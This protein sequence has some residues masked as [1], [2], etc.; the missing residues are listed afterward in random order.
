MSDFDSI[1]KG[2]SISQLA[3]L[4]ELNRRTVTS[5]LRDCA[6]SGVRQSHKIYRIADAAPHLLK[7]LDDDDEDGEG[8]SKKRR[9]GDEKDLWDA[10]L[11]QQKY[12]ENMGD[13]LRRADVALDISVILKNIA[14]QAKLLSDNVEREVGLTHD[15]REIINRLVDEFMNSASNSVATGQYQV[16][17]PDEDE[18]DLSDLFGD[19]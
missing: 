11:K 13:L 12:E 9:P 10:R 4:F 14:L 16:E 1:L 6:A 15:Q 19:C 18:E 3:S 5:R 17:E 8:G 7:L 2:A